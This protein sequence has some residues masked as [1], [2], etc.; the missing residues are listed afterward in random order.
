MDNPL[1]FMFWGVLFGY[2]ELTLWV[3]ALIL[4]LELLR[5]LALQYWRI[6][7]HELGKKKI[8]I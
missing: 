5:R 7:K 6:R 3:Y 2:A 4:T 8:T 1:N